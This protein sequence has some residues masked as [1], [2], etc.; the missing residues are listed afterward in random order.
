M[1][2]QNQAARAQAGMRADPVPR[3]EHRQRR[4]IM[5]G[6]VLGVLV[7]AGGLLRAGEN[8]PFKGLPDLLSTQ[9]ALPAGTLHVDDLFA[10][11]KGYQ[12]SIVVR[13]VMAVPAKDPQ[14]FVMIDSREARVCK[15]LSCAKR[16]LPVK[17]AEPRPKPWE[18]VNVRGTLVTD[19]RMT[20]LQA[21]SVENLGSIK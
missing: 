8:S 12:G 1:S 10:D 15:D 7:V 14:L 17:T 2:K 9:R 16:Y 19:G 13:G 11:L 5:A 20:Y 18:E 21:D 6:L 4:M 3:G